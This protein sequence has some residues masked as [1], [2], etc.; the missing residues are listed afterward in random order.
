MNIQDQIQVKL[1]NLLTELKDVRDFVDENNGWS[2][3]SNHL[4][5]MILTLEKDI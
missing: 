3:L 5:T 2:N 1:N 4:T